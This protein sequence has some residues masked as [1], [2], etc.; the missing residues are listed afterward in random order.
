MPSQPI[1]VLVPSLEEA[2]AQIAEFWVGGVF[3]GHTLPDTAELLLRIEP[4]PDGQPWELSCRELRRSLDRAA[5][6]LRPALRTGE[7]SQTQ[8]APPGR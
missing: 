6:L 3:L 8:T 1:D 7:P 4:R 2:E 5:E